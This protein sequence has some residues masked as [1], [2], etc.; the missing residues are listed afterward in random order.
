MLNAELM[1]TSVVRD[2]LVLH[3][4]AISK[5]KRMLDFVKRHFREFNDS[6]VTK[7]LTTVRWSIP[8][9]NLGLNLVSLYEHSDV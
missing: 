2:L 7:S 8:F 4:K 6:Q 1:R 5:A 9:S 3:L